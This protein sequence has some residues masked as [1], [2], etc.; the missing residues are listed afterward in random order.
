MIAC[1][2]HP[3]LATVTYAHVTTDLA[4][5]K[6][7][8]GGLTVVLHQIQPSV[9]AERGSQTILYK[10]KVVL[11]IR[12]R[13][14]SN[15]M[16]P[17]PIYTE[18]LTPDRKWILYAIDPYGSASY[19]ADGLTTRAIRVTG[20]RSYVVSSGLAFG[21][22][23]SAWCGD[24]LVVT[25]GTNRIATTHKWLIATGPPDWKAQPLVRNPALAFGS[26]VC[27]GDSIVVQEQKA[28][29][30]ANFF[31][32]HWHLARVGF[33][34]SVARLTSPPNGYADESPQLVGGVLYFVRSSHGYGKL[35]ALQSGKIVGP[36][37]SLGYM[38]GYYGHHVWPYTVAP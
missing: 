28:S 24:H 36:L 2:P 4:T 25:A 12:E 38:L 5:C 37:L 8:L 30:D 31:H 16:L 23:Y 34:G 19:P 32:T 26:L 21:G 11:T 3:G 35:Y 20:G 9:V 13:R 10:G 14:T 17:G 7:P 27:D 29:T 33:D 18:G 1:T 15:G 6:R 22:D